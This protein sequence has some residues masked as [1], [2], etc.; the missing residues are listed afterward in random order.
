MRYT[1]FMKPF[2]VIT[3]G[4]AVQDVFLISKDFKLIESA[5]FSTG[6]GECFS[7]GSKVDIKDIYF[8]TGGGATNAATTFANLG[9]RVRVHSRVGADMFGSSI[10]KELRSKK[11]DVSGVIVDKKEKTAYSTILLASGGDRTILTFRGACRSFK[12]SEFKKV[13]AGWIYLTSVA[14][15][16]DM[17]LYVFE[18]AKKIGARIAWNPGGGELSIER[19]ILRKFIT[20]SSVFILN[21]E[22]A[23]RLLGPD[24]ADMPLEVLAKSIKSLNPLAQVVVTDGGNGA[25]CAADSVIIHIG[26]LGGRIVNTTGAGDAF[27]SAFVAGLIKK[28]DTEYALKL[29]ALNADGVIKEMGAKHGLLKR[30]PTRTQLERVPI[31]F[32]L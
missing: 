22:E 26:S 23:R 10:I 7:F 31:K 27:G 3:I 25:V 14:G 8:D 12:S 15:S 28:G 24:A 13:P 6:Y 32:L 18:Y 29:A 20:Q 1:I 16:M 2:D 11:I 21:K 30:L 4:A 9:L 19:E 17:L 5:E